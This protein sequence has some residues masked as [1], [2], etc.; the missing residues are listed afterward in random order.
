MSEANV[1]L[2]RR[3]YAAIASGDLRLVEEFLAPDV[4]WH[5]GDPGAEDGC[6]NREQ[7]LARMRTRARRQMGKLVEVIDAGESV[8]VVM[9]PRR[10][11]QEIPPLRANVTTFRNGRVVEMIAFDSPEA[12]LAHVGHSARPE[13]CD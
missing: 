1:Q 7:A 8:V 12:A 11:G 3:A 2:V 9:Q 6:Q 4:R 5:G 13:R 10:E